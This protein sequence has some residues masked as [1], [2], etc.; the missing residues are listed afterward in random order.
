MVSTM[1]DFFDLQVK[2]VSKEYRLAKGKSIQALG[3]VDF[4][5]KRGDIVSIIGPSGCGK[6]TL[7]RL[8]AG[9]AKPS[10]GEIIERGSDAG[11]RNRGVIFQQYGL[12]PWLTVAE[13]I[14]FGLDL[15]HI[16]GPQQNDIIAHYINVVG[17]KGFEKAYPKE[18]SGG[19]Q[20]RVAL[21][22]TLSTNPHILFM[23]EP[24]AAL[25]VQ[26]KRFMQDLLLQI[27]EHEP[28]TIIFVTHDVE[29]AVFIS[30]HV[31]IMGPHPG[32]IVEK[33]PVH[34]SRPRDLNTE[35]SPEFIELK[36]HVQEV[37][38]KETLGLMKLDLDIYK[39]LN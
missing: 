2:N 12:F 33:I 17:L 31:Y 19:M 37:V 38:T 27:W 10:T 7:V 5:V 24:F 18:L 1:E 8:L 34:L 13:N 25:D 3:V 15:L 4:T 21:A 35:F 6:S 9:L 20:Q 29:E 32:T 30:D 36:H 39:N 22:R 14:G 11:T 28:R 26:T 23:D 16:S